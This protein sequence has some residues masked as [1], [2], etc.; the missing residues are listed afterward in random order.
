[1]KY[2]A[3]E[4][5]RIKTMKEHIQFLYEIDLDNCLMTKEDWIEELAQCMIN[6]T[7]YRVMFWKEFNEYKKQRLDEE[8]NQAILNAEDP[9]YPIGDNGTYDYFLD[10]LDKI[11][12]P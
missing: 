2:N 11:T 12:K 6:P 1:M 3:Q 9:N 5:E 8:D 10:I 4:I 7:K